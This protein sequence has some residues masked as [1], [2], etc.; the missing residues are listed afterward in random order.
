[1]PPTT[2]ILALKRV[3]H[4]NHHLFFVYIVY[5]IVGLVIGRAADMHG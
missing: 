2:R 5:G 4:G 3:I 1:M